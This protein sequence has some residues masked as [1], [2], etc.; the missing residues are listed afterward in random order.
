MAKNDLPKAQAGAAFKA[1]RKGFKTIGTVYKEEKAIAQAEKIAKREKAAAEAK[2]LQRI[3]KAKATREAN[4][5]ARIKAAEEAAAKPK[6]GRKPKATPAPETPTTKKRGRKPKVITGE[7]QGFSSSD[8]KGLGWYY[9]TIGAGT[10][11]TILASKAKKAKSKSATPTET[12]TPTES[13]SQPKGVVGKVLKSAGKYK[14]AKGGSMASKPGA[15]K[16]SKMTTKQTKSAA[17][18][19]KSTGTR[20]PMMRPS[21]KKR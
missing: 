6:R 21:I 20:K 18:A 17:S 10:A 5:A 14:F 8:K 2:K 7:N 4:K 11:A 9:G 3:E 12:T 15:A 19:V 13:T 1:L 16:Y